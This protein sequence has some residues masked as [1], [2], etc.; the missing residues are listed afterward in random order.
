MTW[1][2]IPQSGEVPSFGRYGHTTVLYNK[3]MFI[4]GG[5]KKYNSHLKQ[6][7]CLN[8]VRFF[9]LGF[10]SKKIILDYFISKKIS[11]GNS[12]DQLEI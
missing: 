2:K 7:E 6:H 9:S 4:F 8:D 5:E 3:K 11:N 12:L 10:S 1:E